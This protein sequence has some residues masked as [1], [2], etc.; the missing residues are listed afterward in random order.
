MY[1]KGVVLLNHQWFSLLIQKTIFVIVFCIGFLVLMFCM[2]F[3]P[4]IVMEVS[5]CFTMFV[6]L[7]SFL[8][9]H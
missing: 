2:G 4:T 3:C 7:S 5:F 1:Y 9:K 8:C 6:I